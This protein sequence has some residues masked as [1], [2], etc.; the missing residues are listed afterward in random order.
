MSLTQIVMLWF[1]KMN[2][3]LL[4]WGKGSEQRSTSIG[5]H[6][7]EKEYLHQRHIVQVLCAC[8][9]H[10]HLVTRQRTTTFTEWAWLC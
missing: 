6:I 3:T 5:L 8:N 4:N 1:G 10:K 9:H 7:S 2:L